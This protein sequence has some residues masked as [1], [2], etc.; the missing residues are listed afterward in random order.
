[1]ITMLCN[2]FD[3]PSGATVWNLVVLALK[4]GPVGWKTNS[5]A[6]RDGKADGS[7]HLGQS[8]SV[9]CGGDPE[10]HPDSR[11]HIHARGTGKNQEACRD[12]TGR[13]SIRTIEAGLRRAGMGST[14][15]TAERPL[16]PRCACATRTDGMDPPAIA[17]PSI[18]EEAACGD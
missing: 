13:S 10:R 14:Q 7:F 2:F 6:H 16:L 18:R 11:S 9:N 17:T 12:L 5:G 8:G 1:M 15:R 4:C 3:L